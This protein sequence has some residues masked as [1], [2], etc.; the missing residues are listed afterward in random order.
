MTRQLFNAHGIG[1]QGRFSPLH[2]TAYR[3]ASPRI[4]TALSSVTAKLAKYILAPT[5]AIQTQLKILRR[6]GTV[7]PPLRAETRISLLTFVDDAALW[8]W[9][10]A[11][12][13]NAKD[14]VYVIPTDLCARPFLGLYHQL[15]HPMMIAVQR[16]QT[17][18][19][20]SRVNHP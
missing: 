16:I 1:E 14:A 20:Y 15:T 9:L 3:R 18:E 4:S 6:S 8:S 10:L 11:L 17:I 13:G 7:A 5:E 19:L 2:R 12:D